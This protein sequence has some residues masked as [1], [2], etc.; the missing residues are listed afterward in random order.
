MKYETEEQ[1][2]IDYGLIRSCS[3][4]NDRLN[5][6]D[7]TM[8]SLEDYIPTE[9]KINSCST[10]LAADCSENPV[11]ALFLDVLKIDNERYYG[12]KVYTGG[13]YF[14]LSPG[15][16]N[17]LSINVIQDQNCYNM[18]TTTYTFPGNVDVTQNDV[19]VYQ[20]EEGLIIIEHNKLVSTKIQYN[21]KN[22]ISIQTPG[23]YKNKLCGVCNYPTNYEKDLSSFTY[24][25]DRNNFKCL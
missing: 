6:F 13:N 21:K 15:Q 7:K 19:K 8:I 18:S 14:N 9:N 4:I 5:T 3:I 17:Q 12:L 20:N 23:L 24:C 2:M 1:E 11:F 25:G 16:N 22:I 10:L